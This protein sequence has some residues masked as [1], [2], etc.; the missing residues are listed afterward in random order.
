MSNDSD[1]SS[2]LPPV[3][4]SLV[5]QRF[6]NLQFNENDQDF[7]ENQQF[8]QNQQFNQQQQPNQQ[9]FN[10]QQLNNHHHHQNQQQSNQYYNKQFQP[11]SAISTTQTTPR[12]STSSDTQLASQT[13]LANSPKTSRNS[14]T[15]LKNNKNVQKHANVSQKISPNMVAMSN[16][17]TSSSQGLSQALSQGLSQGLSSKCLSS[18]LSSS[19][20]N[21]GE[22]TC[23]SGISVNN[24]KISKLTPVTHQ[25]IPEMRFQKPTPETESRPDFR[26]DS[27]NQN[28]EFNSE[29]IID[30]NTPTSSVP[31]QKRQFHPQNHSKSSRAVG[32]RPMSIAIDE[33][34][35]CMTNSRTSQPNTPSVMNSSMHDLTD[36]RKFRDDTGFMINMV[37][38][39]KQVQDKNGKN[40]QY[41]KKSNTQT[42]TTPMGSMAKGKL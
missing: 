28:S 1:E 33:R 35:F 24:V 3:P 34:N 4:L 42:P 23:N 17:D 37:E 38:E 13:Q 40:V 26:T 12:N 29:R 36:P 27:R 39:N 31:V 6:E 19:G 18:D 7:S 8:Y 16:S 20:I 22:N 5:T 32:G 25:I 15:K 14:Q 30:D 11:I 10:Q 9:K 2:H 41:R 21:S